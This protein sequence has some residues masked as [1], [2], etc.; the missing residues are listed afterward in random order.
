MMDGTA[1]HA[2]GARLRLLRTRHGLSRPVLAGLVGISVSYLEKLERGDRTTRDLAL[3]GRLARQL[4]VEVADLLPAGAPSPGRSTADARVGAVTDALLDPR[5]LLAP[6]TPAPLTVEEGRRLAFQLDAAWRAFQAAAYARTATL[7]PPLIRRLGA[8]GQAGP[9]ALG[10]SAHHAAAALL[11]H[12]GAADLALVSAERGL[13]IARSTELPVAVASLSRS[14]AHALAAGGRAR[15]ALSLTRVAAA[16]SRR[17]LA[18]PATDAVA[19]SVQGTLLLNG[20]MAAARCGESREALA[21]LDEA[22]VSAHRLGGDHNAAW[23]AFGP[24]NV[25]LHRIG[26]AVATDDVDRALRLAERVD[27]AGL[28]AERRA[29]LHL[30][31]AR[32][33]ARRARHDLAVDRLLAAHRTAPEL[34][35]VHPGARDV[36]ASLVRGPALRRRDFAELAVRLGGQ[37]VPC[38]SV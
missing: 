21:L 34:L 8:A 5:Q 36:V 9:P 15:A 25:A 13:G 22:E 6:D 26:V 10:A 30:D 4:R 3:L 12:L 28:P 24:G 35:A 38:G 18:V 27:V 7:L 33:A 32:S 37:G 16:E 19:L 11:A 29:R 2:D 23:T 1:P 17:H 20:A 14:V 31:V